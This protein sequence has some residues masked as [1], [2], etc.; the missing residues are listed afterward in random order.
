ARPHRQRPRRLR[1]EER[2]R[3]AS[4]RCRPRRRRPRTGGVRAG[5]RLPDLLRALCR[6]GGRRRGQPGCGP[7]RVGQRRTDRGQR[8][9]RCA[10]RAGLERGDSPAGSAAQRR[11]RAVHRCAHA[12]RGRGDALPRRLLEHAVLRGPP[13]RAP[14][15]AAGCVRT[16]WNAAAFRFGRV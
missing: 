16:R 5:R 6:G 1:P 10:S 2:L 12:H 13:A 11:Q 8:R 9:P 7:R 4:A 15:V 3:A 14:A